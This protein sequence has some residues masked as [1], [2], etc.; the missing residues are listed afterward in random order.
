MESVMQSAA[1]NRFFGTKY[2]P[3]AS[4]RNTQVCSELVA[5]FFTDVLGQEL[6][7]DPDVAGPRRLNQ[8]IRQHPELCKP[9]GKKVVPLR[10][11]M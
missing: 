9:V 11:N 4:G 8:F 10:R 6:D 1:W 3:L 5:Y 2:N 7:F